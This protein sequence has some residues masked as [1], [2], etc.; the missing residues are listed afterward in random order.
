MS[1]NWG[2]AGMLSRVWQLQAGLSWPIF[3][4]QPHQIYVDHTGG[5]CSIWS[6]CC[7]S[8]KRD[9]HIPLPKEQQQ[10]SCHPSL[11]KMSLIFV[12]YPG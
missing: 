2:V 6:W 12:T 5:E 8:E 7:N 11:A 10:K 1:Q 3:P 4:I 9:I